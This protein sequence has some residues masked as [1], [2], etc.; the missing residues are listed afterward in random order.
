MRSGTTVWPGDTP[1]GRPPRRPPIEIGVP[2]SSARNAPV[3]CVYGA[4]KQYSRFVAFDARKFRRSLT[5]R[6]E[7]DGTITFCCIFPP[8]A[9]LSNRR[10]WFHT[11]I[12]EGFTDRCRARFPFLT[13]LNAHWYGPGTTVW[14]RDTPLGRPP[15]GL[16]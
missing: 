6:A 15:A 13:G 3:N 11:R 7:N 8:L 1:L 16:D 10:C 14:P 4:Q 5:F 12:S 2:K 9:A